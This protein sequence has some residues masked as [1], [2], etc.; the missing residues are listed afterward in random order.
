MRALRDV[1]PTNEQLGILSRSELGVKIIRGA[2]GS[3]KTTTALL[4]LRS[5]VGVFV[6]RR[7]RVRSEKSVRILVLTYNRTLRGL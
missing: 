5:L 7:R 6:N 2:A 3:G 1:P 4:R